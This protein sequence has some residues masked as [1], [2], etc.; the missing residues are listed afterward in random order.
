[1]SKR[2]I[3]LELKTLTSPLTCHVIVN[4]IIRKWNVFTIINRTS[5]VVWY[6]TKACISKSHA[7]YLLHCKYIKQTS[8]QEMILS[9]GLALIK[10]GHLYLSEALPKK[11]SSLDMN[12]NCL[13][14]VLQSHQDGVALRNE[15]K[16]GG[17]GGVKSNTQTTCWHDELHMFWGWLR[18]ERRLTSGTC[19]A[20]Q[21]AH[22]GKSVCN[23]TDQLVRQEN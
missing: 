18:A 12:C 22:W 11:V 19:G 16:G 9:P 4:K 3:C 5:Q 15:K 21:G 14:D 8:C 17:G 20:A 7:S 13:Q 2:N 23:R 1:M 10:S 6:V